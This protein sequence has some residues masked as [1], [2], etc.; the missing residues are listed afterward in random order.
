MCTHIFVHIVCVHMAKY[1]I[2]YIYK[3]RK[4]G[5]KLHMSITEGQKQSSYKYKAKNIKRIPLD[6][7]KEKYEEIKSHADSHK[8]IVNGYIKKAIDM[9]ME[10]DNINFQNNTSNLKESGNIYTPDFK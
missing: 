7:Q 5:D 6:V 8:E 9:R 2:L 4:R 1:M 10:S 3:W